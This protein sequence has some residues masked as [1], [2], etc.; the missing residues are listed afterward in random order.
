M[1]TI[2]E[3]QAELATKEKEYALLYEET[4]NY[5]ERLENLSNQIQYIKNKI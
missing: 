4:Q 5:K 1:K 2:E 3:L